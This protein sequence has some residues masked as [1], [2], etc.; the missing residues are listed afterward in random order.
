MQG[1]DREYWHWTDLNIGATLELYGRTIT[2]TNSDQFTRAH[3][4]SEG[5]ELAPV[6]PAPCD[7][8]QV[9]HYTT[10][11]AL[12]LI[13]GYQ[14]ERELMGPQ[15]QMRE[16]QT[17][18]TYDSLRQFLHH[19]RKVLRF[20]CHSKLPEYPLGK[21]GMKK[22]IICFFLADNSLEVRD[23]RDT[24]ESKGAGTFPKFL[25]RQRLPKSRTGTADSFPSMTAA[26]QQ[27]YYAAEDFM[28]GKTVNILKHDFF[29][30][31]MD[32]FTRKFYR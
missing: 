22:Y 16:H 9:T 25:K 27:D 29:I 21:H 12:W 10:H 28:I 14:D 8:Y 4:A 2:L 20:Y 3:L 31:D 13:H 23:V 15:G 7:S 30:Y 24:S 17:K 11:S 26:V 6:E 18:D 32:D 19:D 5:V 1:A